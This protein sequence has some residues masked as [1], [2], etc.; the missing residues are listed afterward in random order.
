MRRKLIAGNWKMFK[1]A[2]EAVALVFAELALVKA[3]VGPVVLACAVFEAVEPGAVVLGAV[4][5]GGEAFAGDVRGRS[6]DR[7]GTEVL[8]WVCANGSGA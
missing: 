3:A 5:P 6:V 7:L 4:G 1:T 8:D 2:A